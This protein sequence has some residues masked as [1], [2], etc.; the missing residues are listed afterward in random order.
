M[1][2]KIITLKVK[3]MNQG[4]WSNL[5]LEL[6][7]IRKAWKSYG[8]DI[9]L[10][11]PGLRNTILWGTKVNDYTRPSRRPGKRVQSNKRPTA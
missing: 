2:E 9:G 3:G 8:V 7:L 11:A 1:K 6:N 4:Q 10:K 5:L